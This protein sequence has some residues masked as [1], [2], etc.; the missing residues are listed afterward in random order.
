MSIPFLPVPLSHLRIRFIGISKGKKMKRMTT[1][2]VLTIAATVM[3]VP[4]QVQITAPGA[5][6][7]YQATVVSGPI[8]IYGVGETFRTFC[9]E[10]HENSSNGI[11][12]VVLGDR[13]MDGGVEPA[14]TGDPLDT[15][16]AFLYN[17]FLN[18]GLAAYGIVSDSASYTIMQNV[19]WEIEGDGN[20]IGL[21]AG[22][23]GGNLLSY[24]AANAD[25]SNYGIKVMVMHTATGAKAQDMPVKF[26]I[27][28][29]M[30]V[31]L[32]GLGGVLLIRNKK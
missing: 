10:R 12:D 6:Y 20:V 14:G 11:F 30:T 8:G 16:T 21:G 17:E 23:I 5:Y 29:P 27:P 28:E 31:A 4:L 2:V 13:A 15:K 1:L 7:D 25:G 9:L 22:T 32:L 24:A 26:A 18:G 3:A 19:I